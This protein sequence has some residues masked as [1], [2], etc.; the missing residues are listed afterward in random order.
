VTLSVRVR[1]LRCCNQECKQIIFAERA[2]ELVAGHA[3]RTTRLG[4][5]Q[6][7]VGLAVGGEAGARLVD[8]LDPMIAC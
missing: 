8:R 5:I 7:T 6:R 2:E 1:R 3:R 4:N